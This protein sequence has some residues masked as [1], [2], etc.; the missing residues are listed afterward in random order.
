[1][2]NKNTWAIS[3]GQKLLHRGETVI[4]RRLINS[5]TGI[6]TDPGHSEWD[7]QP[8]KAQ[9]MPAPVSDARL[10]TLSGPS[11]KLR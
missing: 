8:F 6:F 3:L 7:R 10:I 5:S 11:H 1:M 9:Q 4:L 2:N